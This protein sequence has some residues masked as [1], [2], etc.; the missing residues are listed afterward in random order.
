MTTR[1]ESLMAVLMGLNITFEVLLPVPFVSFFIDGFF[2]EIIGWKRMYQVLLI[3]TLAFYF[4]K[5]NNMITAGGIIRDYL[6]PLYVLAF[7]PLAA[8]L[9]IFLIEIFKIIYRKIFPG[10]YRRLNQ[11]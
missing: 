9:E 2:I 4:S 1:V 10:L 7:L 3:A 6:F 8:V 11:I 5:L